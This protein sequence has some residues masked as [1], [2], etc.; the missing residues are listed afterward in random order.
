[1]ETTE[2][3]LNRGGKIENVPFGKTGIEPDGGFSYIT[4]AESRSRKDAA[5]MGVKRGSGRYSAN[6]VSIMDHMPWLTMK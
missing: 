5:E 2:D 4:R 3:Y 6:V 1:M